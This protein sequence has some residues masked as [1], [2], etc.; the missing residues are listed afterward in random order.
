MQ[1]ERESEDGG[2]GVS[3]ETLAK[4]EEKWPTVGSSLL[5]IAQ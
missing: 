5:T 3:R 1:S 4:G 2:L